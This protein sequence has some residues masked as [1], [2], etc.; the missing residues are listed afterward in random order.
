MFELVMIWTNLCTSKVVRSHGQE[1]VN[2]VFMIGTHPCIIT[3]GGTR[4]ACKKCMRCGTTSGKW[5]NL[6][7]LRKQDCKPKA[8]RQAKRAGKAP[9]KQKGG[10]EPALPPGSLSKGRTK[11]PN[12]ILKRRLSE[13]AEQSAPL[14]LNN[15]HDL[16]EREFGESQRDKSPLPAAAFPDSRDLTSVGGEAEEVAPDPTTAAAVWE[17]RRLPLLPGQLPLQWHPAADSGRG[18]QTH[19]YRETS[20][21][22]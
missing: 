16:V 12:K 2:R 4:M 9:Q 10:A 19:H 11:G 17:G 14:V 6:G 15:L 22:V 1:T 21:S 8:K 20:S 18:S 13:P 5:R 7:T 3:A